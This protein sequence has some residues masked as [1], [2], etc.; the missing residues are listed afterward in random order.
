MIH[1]SPEEAIAAE[2]FAQAN[3]AV[4]FLLVSLGYSAL[5][6]DHPEPFAWFSLFISLIWLFSIGG[7]YRSIL[8]YYLPK[9]ASVARHISIAWQLKTFI[10]SLGFVLAV[11]LGMTAGDICLLLGY[12]A[13]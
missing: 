13:G 12:S 7:P 4:A 8:K 5:Q 1:R 11:A 10:I 3:G 2:Y 9:G 6:S